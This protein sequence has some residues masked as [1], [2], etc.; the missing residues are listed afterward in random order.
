MKRPFRREIAGRWRRS[1]ARGMARAGF[2]PLAISIVLRLPLAVCTE[3]HACRQ[4]PAGLWSAA[5]KALFR[6]VGR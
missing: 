6:E 3:I 5:E 4:A 1:A 2:A